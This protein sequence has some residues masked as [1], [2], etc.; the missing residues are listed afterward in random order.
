MRS[1]LALIAALTITGAP[2]AHADPIDYGDAASWLCKPAANDRCQ[3]N[4]DAVA[5]RP[6]GS[7]VPAPFVP[8]RN[9]EVDCFYVYPTASREPGPY[10]DMQASP[11]LVDT[12]RAQ[13]GRLASRCRLFAPIY[14]QLT[15]PG[16]AASM[17]GGQALDWNK[18]YEDVLAA[19]RWYLAHENKGRGVVLV[20]HSQGTIMLRK[21][22]AEEIDGKPAQR[23][24]V[25]AFLAGSPEG[26]AFPGV[27]ACHA[28]GDTGCVYVWGSYRESD[29]SPRR[30]FG[31]KT[32]GNQDAVCVNPAGPEGGVKPLTS[33]LPKPAGSPA[34]AP[35][36]VV[37]D[38]A[39]S[40]TCT[41][42]Q[43]GNVLR[44]TGP[45]NLPES[46]PGWGLH[47]WDISLVQGNILA[48]LDA[49][50]ANWK[51]GRQGG[52]D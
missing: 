46:A 39:F 52:A 40:A 12:A 48:L 7:R 5:I 47:R 28:A 41:P 50:A 31:R 29:L 19:W 8:A 44:V 35:A 25:S 49:Q 14:R 18:P 20:G 37:V 11:E 17:S 36:W 4:L 38:G 42:D 3:R 6:D 45:A 43:Q 30:A 15:L 23:L 9:P 34:E 1:T 27:K 13:A 2:A 16:L 51:R 24:L 22:I 32:S 26:A 33:F 21:L 10:A